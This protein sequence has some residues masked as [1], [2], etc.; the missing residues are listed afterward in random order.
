MLLQEFLENS[1][2]RHPDREALVSGDRRL[3]FGE[4]DNM[5]NQLAHTLRDSGVGYGDR[6]AI[7]ID[8]SPETVIALWAVLKADA[9]FLIINPT[10]KSDKIRYIL[11]NCRAAALI[12]HQSRWRQAAE[13]AAE[14]ESLKTVIC[15][16]DKAGELKESSPD[17]LTF[18][19]LDEALNDAPGTRPERKAIDIDLA[20]LIYTSGSTGN[21]KGVMLTHL[22]MV[23]AS[24]SV[25]TYLENTEN[26]RIINVL[27]LSFDYGLYQVIMAAQ[28]SGTVILERS[29]TYPYQTIKLIHE[30][31]ATGFPIVPTMSAILLQM[32][33]LAKEDFSNLRYITNTAAALPVSHINGLR[34]VF[35]STKIY[36]MYG[37]TECKRVSYLHPDQIDIRPES[38]GK[39][40]PNE[41]VYLVD[42][43]D[44]LITRPDVT[45]ELVVR[46]ANVMKGYWELPEETARRLR[47]GIH[48][49]EKSLYTGDLFRMDK[50]GYLYFVSRR[51]DIIKSRGEKVSP[52]EVENALYAIEDVVEAAV[53]GVPDDIL[54]EAVKAFVVLKD[55]SELSEKAII[56][57][58]SRN[59]EDF[60]VPKIIEL[61]ESLP[62]TTTGKITTKNL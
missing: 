35:P 43:N 24:T 14:A 22:N 62:R 8:N 50:E 42:E 11:G 3:S 46:G 58:C 17:T 34:D 19:T 37:L 4:I 54:G 16:G 44:D 26:D 15:A 21:P 30:E 6:V 18:L 20:A 51:D 32:K 53:T 52:R 28:F 29:F 47:P 9:V 25:S 27:P 49:W 2:S 1:A 48:P 36:S 10:T 57:H 55:G 33:E 56:A 23:A 31:K 38:V 61:R 40:M 13:A 45:G 41:Q 5:A 39:G 12:T 60:M 7:L 59:L